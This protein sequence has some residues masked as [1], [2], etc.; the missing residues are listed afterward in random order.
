MKKL[1]ALCISLILALSLTACVDVEGLLSDLEGEMNIP[2]DTETAP[3]SSDTSSDNGVKIEESKTLDLYRRI[4][5]DREY[6]LI[7]TSY[8]PKLDGSGD[9]ESSGG[10]ENV[11]AYQGEKIYKLQQNALLGAAKKIIDGE[12]IYGIFDDTQ[13]V[14]KEKYRPSHEKNSDIATFGDGEDDYY[15]LVGDPTQRE[16]WGKSYYCEHFSFDAESIDYLY[17]GDQLRFIIV[18]IGGADALL[19]VESLSDSADENLFKIPE[20]YTVFG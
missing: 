14:I 6:T 16:V 4:L 15:N 18:D 20:G 2:T 9:F 11:R 8:T 13:Q 5:A 17:E 19:K 3:S 1:L 7:Y 10:T 12:Y